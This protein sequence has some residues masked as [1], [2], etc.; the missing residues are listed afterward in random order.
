[1]KIWAGLTPFA[2]RF[3]IQV[4]TAAAIAGLAAAAAAPPMFATDVNVAPSSC[5]APFLDQ[6]FPMYFHEN[7]VMNPSDNIPT[8]VICGI[9]F[10]NDLINI[11]SQTTIGVVGS[12]MAGASTESPQCYFTVNSLFNTTQFPYRPGNNLIYTTT[13]PLT[14]NS[15]DQWVAARLVSYSDVAAAV[16][17]N[18]DY[19]VA[20][21]WCRLPS[22]HS[23]SG[24]VA[25]DD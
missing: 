5:K 6:A 14:G 3:G 19:W 10:D 13:L 12:E 15:A 2:G 20:T 8:W 1:M 23:I 11:T 4:R 9:P 21:A 24:V 22:G 7:Y 25:T 17:S 18:P 16:G